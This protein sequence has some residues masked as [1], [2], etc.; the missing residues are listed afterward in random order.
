MKVNYFANFQLAPSSIHFQNV[1]SKFDQFQFKKN[2]MERNPLMFVGILAKQWKRVRE[3]S[4]GQCVRH[5][6]SAGKTQEWVTRPPYDIVRASA[7]LHLK[8]TQT[9]SRAAPS[10]ELDHIQKAVRAPSRLDFLP[11]QPLFFTLAP[12]DH[13]S[14]LLIVHLLYLVL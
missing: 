13:I 6:P 14:R 12:L 9:W 7:R 5:S 4:V 8:R 1:K 10:K 2:L 11:Q 3:V